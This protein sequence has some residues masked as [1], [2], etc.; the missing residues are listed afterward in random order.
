MA[1]PR[2]PGLRDVQIRG[3][4]RDDNPFSGVSIVLGFRG[5]GKLISASPLVARDASKALQ[6][7]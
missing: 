1:S 6:S 2:F 4:A 7:N 5:K 3:E